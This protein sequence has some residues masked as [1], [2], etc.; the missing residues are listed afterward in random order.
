MRESRFQLNAPLFPPLS[1]STSSLFYSPSGGILRRDFLMSEFI[2]ELAV[3]PVQN[4]TN[5]AASIHM[6]SE[7][8][9]KL[10]LA[11]PL[12]ENLIKD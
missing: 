11:P 3:Y 7:D 2:L 1:F 5:I 10:V 4:L 9:V 6:S 12:L 8:A